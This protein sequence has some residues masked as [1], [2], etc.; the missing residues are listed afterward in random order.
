M[1]R[2]R[3]WQFL[4]QVARDIDDQVWFKSGPHGASELGA[5]LY[6]QQSN[7][8]VMYGQGRARGDQSALPQAEQQAQMEQAQ[9]AADTDQAPEPEKQPD[10]GRKGR[11]R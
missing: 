3:V 2:N 10:R 11:S 9:A 6:G 7:A 5:A 8:Y 1:A 4:R